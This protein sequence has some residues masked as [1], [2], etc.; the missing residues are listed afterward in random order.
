MSSPVRLDALLSRFGYCSRSEARAW[1]KA[2][3]VLVGA[4]IAKSPS[5]KAAPANVLV[6]GEPVEHPHGILALDSD[7]CVWARIGDRDLRGLLA[8]SRTAGIVIPCIVLGLRGQRRWTG[9][10]EAWEVWLSEVSKWRASR[11]EPGSGR[12]GGTTRQAESI[13]AFAPT[14]PRRSGS[15]G[16]SSKRAHSAKTGDPETMLRLPGSR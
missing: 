5:D 8:D 3:R 11:R 2:G 10:P 16:R 7:V 14:R 4:V 9:G 12:S 13:G 6:D 1:I 15:S